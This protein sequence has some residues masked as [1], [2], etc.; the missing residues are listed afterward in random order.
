M[1]FKHLTIRGF[2]LFEITTDDRRRAAA[3]EFVR[4]GLATGEL[5]AVIDKVFPLE[6]IADAHRYLEAGG[7]VGKIV[8]TVTGQESGA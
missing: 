3:V 5:A 4:D 6:A 2:E 1:L 8:V 7:Q